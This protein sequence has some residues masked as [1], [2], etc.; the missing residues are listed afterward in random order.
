MSP[1]AEKTSCWVKSRV[2]YTHS[3]TI[4]IA[5]AVGIAIAMTS[6]VH[7]PEGPAPIRCEELACRAAYRGGTLG[8][9]GA[10]YRVTAGISLRGILYSNKQIVYVNR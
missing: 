8:S 1:I 7:H 9:R 2:H 10:R 3:I 5:S 4:A 6:P